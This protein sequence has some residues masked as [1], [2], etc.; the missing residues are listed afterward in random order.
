[1]LARREGM[2]AAL[3]QRYYGEDQRFDY[4]LSRNFMEHVATR[5]PQYQAWFEE[6]AA[7][8]GLDW[9]LLAAMGYQESKWDARRCRSPACAD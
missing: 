9:R 2:V 7:A 1:M 8:H 3:L 4:L 6:A 5:L